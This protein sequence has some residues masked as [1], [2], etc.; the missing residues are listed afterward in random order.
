M[1]G[2]HPWIVAPD[3]VT[4]G[5]MF[6]VTVRLGRVPHPQEPGHHIEYVHLKMGDVLLAATTFHYEWV[7]PETTVAL[8]LGE[9]TDLTAFADCNLHGLWAETKRIQVV[10]K[11]GGPDEGE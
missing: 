3:T 6:K 8:K 5:E 9:S 11:G 4:V 2:Q 1:C 10:E 7:H